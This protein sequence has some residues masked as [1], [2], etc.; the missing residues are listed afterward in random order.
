MS[1]DKR[2]AFTDAVINGT[3]LNNKKQLKKE[4]IE[5]FQKFGYLSGGKDY[6]VTFR[7]TSGN[8]AWININSMEI[9]K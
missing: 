3:E 7:T 6:E 1:K 8:I 4:L 5:V 2:F 9:I